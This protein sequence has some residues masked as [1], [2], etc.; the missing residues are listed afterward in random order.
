MLPKRRIILLLAL[1]ASPCVALEFELTEQLK[2][3]EA[4]FRFTNDKDPDPL[5]ALPFAPDGDNVI[6]SSTTQHTVYCNL[7]EIKPRHSA[8]NFRYVFYVVPKAPQQVRATRFVVYG[9]PGGPFLDRWLEVGFEVGSEGKLEEGSIRLPILS[10]KGQFL[11]IIPMEPVKVNFA[12]GRKVDLKLRS[13]LQD[14]ETIVT[15]SRAPKPGDETYWESLRLLVDGEDNSQEFSVAAG[16]ESSALILQLQPNL[17]A[18]LTA[19]SFPLSEEHDHVTVFLNYQTRWGWRRSLEIP[20]AVR[21]V[22]WPPI[23]FVAVAIGTFFGSAILALTQ[24]SFKIKERTR[25]FLVSL[26]TALLAELVAMFLKYNNSEFRLFG[27]EFDP[28]D[29]LPAFL[30]GALMGLLGLRS[31]K[32]LNQWFPSFFEAPIPK[33]A[34]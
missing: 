12:S 24:K 18:A 27:F 16:E 32:K 21:F 20:V 34:P 3:E 11:E 7:E 6:S 4:E 22:P 13:K 25:I 14:L 30:V 17:G 8:Y 23:L 9:R 10:F 28:F 2:V 15:W 19:S 1:V 26:T 33:G 31:L 29:I 5:Q